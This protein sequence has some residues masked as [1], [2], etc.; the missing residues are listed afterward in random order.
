MDFLVSTPPVTNTN[1][2]M[3]FCLRYLLD[4]YLR[5]QAIRL[6]PCAIGYGFCGLKLEVT[7]IVT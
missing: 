1:L 4:Y 2:V 7:E 3:L 5:R 6:D